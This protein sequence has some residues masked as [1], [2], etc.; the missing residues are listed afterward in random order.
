[1]SIEL[2]R[3]A[4][5]T[6]AFSGVKALNDVPFDLYAREAHALLGENGAGK[7]TLM[8][9]ISGVYTRDAG[10]FYINGAKIDRDLSPQTAQRLGIGIIHQELNLCPHLTVTE[11]IFLNR[12]FTCGGVLRAK[13]QVQEAKQY[14]ETL[15]LD[16]DPAMPVRKLPV[17][18]QQ[19]VE[20]CKTLS[21]T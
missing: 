6:K 8:K 11:N 1:M 18:K 7:S 10:D 12:E 16:I 21:S 13:K 2:I 15:H 3:V 19:M 5:I 9:I 14:L 17:S 4:H 20:I